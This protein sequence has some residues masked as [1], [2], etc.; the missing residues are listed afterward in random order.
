MRRVSLRNAMNKYKKYTNRENVLLLLIST[1]IFILNSYW[2]F[3]NRRGGILDI[4][5]AGYLTMA[6]NNWNSIGLE[7]L[8]GF[9]QSFVN[10]PLHAPLQPAMSALLFIPVGPKIFIALLTPTIFY[11]GIFAVVYKILRRIYPSLESLGLAFFVSQ[12]NFL[13]AYSRNYNFAIITTFFVMLALY[14][15]VF[16][17]SISKLENVILGF[18]LGGILLSRTVS[19]IYLP[20]L[21]VIFIVI[22]IINKRKKID[23][24]KSVII[25]SV[26]FLVV[27]YP[28]LNKNF[29]LVYTYLTSYGY[30]ERSKEYGSENYA[31]SFTNILEQIY[32]YTIYQ[33]SITSILVFIFIPLY[34]LF[35]KFLKKNVDSDAKELRDDGNKVQILTMLFFILG[36]TLVIMS[37]RNRGSGFEIPLIITF[38]LLLLY[39]I[40]IEFNK[41]IGIFIIILLFLQTTIFVSPKALERFPIKDLSIP[42][43]RIQIQLSPDNNITLSYLEGGLNGVILSEAESQKYNWL[44][45]GT[46]QNLEWN[47][48]KVDLIRFL[49]KTNS[50]SQFV[51]LATRHR[52]INPNSLNLIR[53]QERKEMIPFRFL[54]A[55]EISQSSDSEIREIISREFETKPCTIIT[56]SGKLNEIL[57]AVDQKY[58]TEKL[59]QEQYTLRIKIRLPD[60]RDVELFQ[61]MRICPYLPKE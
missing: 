20:F 31:L 52:I 49:E 56:S 41:F 19:V 29:T 25:I 37:S 23:T 24:L 21:A 7:G 53:A 42:F 6:W 36:S 11:V 3:S 39:T 51:L 2:I 5:E 57:P 27:I 55:Q 59:K 43:T 38:H 54:P 60:D 61:N 50:D 44:L 28:W 32:R 34:F 4:D 12:L 17:N 35:K 8:F 46:D 14:L 48:A 47:K 9:S 10:Q 40:R 16:K 1:L 13:V 30:G 22:Q 18:V 58:I 15:I 45:K 33:Y 26:S